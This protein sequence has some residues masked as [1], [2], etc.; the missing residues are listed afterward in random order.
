MSTNINRK[1]YGVVIII[2]SS[3]LLF[4]LFAVL[5][6]NG[7]VITPTSTIILSKLLVLLSPPLF[8][9]WIGLSF[10]ANKRTATQIVLSLVIFLIVAMAI[11]Y[12]RSVR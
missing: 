8:G 12:L 7:T 10:Y 2:L 4:A 3:I 6:L 11:G 9:V 1:R 5:G